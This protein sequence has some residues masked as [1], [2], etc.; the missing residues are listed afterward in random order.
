[1]NKQLLLFWT[2]ALLVLAGGCVANRREW[3]PNPAPKLLLEPPADPLGMANRIVTSLLIQSPLRDFSR[4]H[5]LRVAPGNADQPELAAMWT[6]LRQ[7]LASERHLRLTETQPDYVL[8]GSLAALA[9]AP[10]QQGLHLQLRD[11]AGRLVWRYQQPLASAPPAA[12]AR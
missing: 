4:G 5:T 3:S 8:A 6:Q 2:L 12:E 1:M 7:K 11:A 10:G 9:D